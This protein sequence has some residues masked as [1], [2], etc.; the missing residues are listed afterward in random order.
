MHPPGRFIHIDHL[1]MIGY[2]AE[3]LGE[4][5]HPVCPCYRW[6]PF[7]VGAEG[8]EVILILEIGNKASGT[9]KFE[10]RLRVAIFFGLSSGRNLNKRCIGE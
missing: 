3:Q 10:R 4:R 1:F 2:I 9:L 8:R 6:T 5:H 7:P